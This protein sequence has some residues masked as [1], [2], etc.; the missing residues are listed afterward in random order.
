MLIKHKIVCQIFLF[1]NQIYALDIQVNRGWKCQIWATP[2]KFVQLRKKKKM[3]G[4]F[5]VK[6]NARTLEF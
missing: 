2:D 3:G 5:F 6:K 1:L 4:D